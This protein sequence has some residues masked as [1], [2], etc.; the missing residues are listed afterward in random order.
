MQA[1]QAAIRLILALAAATLTSSAATDAVASPATQSVAFQQ[2]ASHD[3]FIADAAIATPLQEL[4]SITL[5]ERISNPLIVNGTV[6]VTTVNLSTGETTLHARDQ[7]TGAARWSRTESNR[8]MSPA[9]D[10]GQIFVQHLNNVLTAFDA[11]TGVTNWRKQMPGQS[12]SDVAPTAK[13][14]IVYVAGSGGG[15]TLYAVRERD[16]HVLWTR[17]VANGMISSPA[18]DGGSVYVTYPCQR[19]AF[20]RI[21]G[22]TDWHYDGPCSGGGGNTA[23]VGA[24]RLFA[25]GSPSNAIH[26]A[27]TGA[28]L[29]PL[30]SHT[31]PAVAGNVAYLLRETTLTAKADAGLGST[32]WQF[33]G[34]GHVRTAPVVVGDTVFVGSGEGKLYALNAATGAIRQTLDVGVPMQAPDEFSNGVPMAGFG[35]ANGTLVVPAGDKLV[36]YRTAG[37]ITQAPVNSSLPAIDGRAQD[38]ELLVADVGIWSNLPTG[39]DYA[40]QRCDGAGASCADVGGAT[41]MSFKPAASDVGSTF[42][43]RVTA[44]NAS[45][46]AAP[47][48]SAQSSVVTPAPPEIDTLPSITGTPREGLELVATPGVWTNSPSSYGYAWQHCTQDFFPTCSDIQGATES[49]YTADSEDI[50]LVLRVRVVAT[51]AGGDSDAAVSAPTATVAMGPP[52]AVLAPDFSGLLYAGEQL[53][54][55]LGQWTNFPTSFRQQWYSCDPAGTSCPDI[56]GA[57]QLTY[58]LR[59][60]DVGRY[61]GVEVVATNAVGDS[62]PEPSGEAGPVYPAIPKNVGAPSISG[63]GRAGST[64]TAHPGTWTANPSAFS[65]WWYRCDVRFVAC[66][67][68]GVVGNSYLLGASDVGQML[69]IGVV[70]TNAGVDSD[71]WLSEPVGPIAAAAAPVPPPPPPVP[72]PTSNAFTVVSQRAGADGRLTFKLRAPRAGTFTAV[73]TAGAAALR[74][75]CRPRCSATRRSSFGRGSRKAGA[76]GTVSLV[77]KPN[78]RARA[79]LK[80]R[81]GAL[82]VRV[83]ITYKPALGRSSSQVRSLSVR[84]RAASRSRQVARGAGQRGRVL[85][86]PGLP[87]VLAR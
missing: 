47:L 46:A 15:G 22:E 69:L 10:R 50:G 54:A 52:S 38:G 72:P 78:A 86:L 45:G 44:S 25:R 73:A 3:G 83:Q 19:Y 13:D 9:Y 30:D 56:A 4:W 48:A 8:S 57:N 41:G 2:N 6:Y 76:A 24:G 26:S 23:V 60:A 35:A 28:I 67:F 79:A 55:H 81:G 42:R 84:R 18:V 33:S 40:W 43:V 74:D 51:N 12:S 5:P 63:T 64:L 49:S 68:T 66:G 34:D 61:I 62:R 39:Y 7:A 36:A 20:D 82:R 87:R 14:G 65:T 37:A 80:R 1:K 16:G 53:G 75:P 71:E 85:G 32:L 31:V 17:S 21:S 58:V 27:A 59:D 29:G 77:V 70:A 11:A